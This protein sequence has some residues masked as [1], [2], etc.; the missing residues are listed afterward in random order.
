MDVRPTWEQVRLKINGLWPR[1]DPTEAER[2]LIV[3]RLSKLEMRWLD[4]AVESYRCETSSTV[5]RLAELME[6][7]KRISSTGESK[8]KMPSA[9]SE[10]MAKAEL[11]REEHE[12]DAAAAR[13]WLATQPRDRVAS[14]IKRL[15]ETGWVG[16]DPIP[17]DFAAWKSNTALAVRARIELD[18]Q[19]GAR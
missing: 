3:S 6:H 4:A 2:Q 18:E 11:H 17:S 19:E 7:Y 13:A 15:R 16:R 14:A 8:G 9:P 10:V 5:F 1:F 12:R